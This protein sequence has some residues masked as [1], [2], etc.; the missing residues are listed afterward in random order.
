MKAMDEYQHIN[1][2]YQSDS[3]LEE[4]GEILKMICF[5]KMKKPYV[6]EQMKGK[7]A[8]MFGIGGGR[9]YCYSFFGSRN[10]KINFFEECNV[11]RL[12]KQDDY[13]VHFEDFKKFPENFMEQLIEK[14]MVDN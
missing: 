1:F 7:Y 3:E 9:S 12:G 14:N 5:C 10:V 6:K 4:V 11:T 13:F 2:N 8:V